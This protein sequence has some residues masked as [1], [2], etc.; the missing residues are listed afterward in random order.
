MP[1]NRNLKP[2]TPLV[3]QYS[4]RSADTFRR[5]SVGVVLALRKPQPPA[6]APQPIDERAVTHDHRRALDRRELI[7]ALECDQH[8]RIGFDLR[9][10]RR[11]DAGREIGVGIRL[12]FGDGHR[13]RVKAAVRLAG[14][15]HGG[16]EV[17]CQVI[18][19]LARVHDAVPAGNDDICGCRW[20]ARH[21]WNVPP[22]AM[23][24]RRFCDP[25]NP[26][27]ARFEEPNINDVRLFLLE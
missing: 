8:A 3:S 21:A 19:V 26:R 18:E 17:F 5:H 20:N 11:L 23:H 13:P 7:A 9:D 4:P 27:R 24:A 12:H 14:D 10:L 1:S 22:T 15:Q 6:L 2:W 25:R 16:L